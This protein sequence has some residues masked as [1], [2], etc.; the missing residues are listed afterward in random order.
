[1]L[2]D[3][4]Q[5]LL[6]ES[7]SGP[8]VALA[9]RSTHAQGGGHEDLCPQSPVRAAYHGDLPRAEPGV[10]S[11]QALQ[12]GHQDR[13]GVSSACEMPELQQRSGGR[14]AR[15]PDAQP[16]VAADEARHRTWPEHA[17]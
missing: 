2:V 10:Q 7:P 8:S 13:P 4:L 3:F 15:E 1:M 11:P 6:E 16:I 14:V 17:P 12:P 9:G 5:T